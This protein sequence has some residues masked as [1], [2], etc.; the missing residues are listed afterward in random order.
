MEPKIFNPDKPIVLALCGKAGTGKTSVADKLVPSRSVH[1]FGPLTLD[2]T[3][4]AAPLY[5]MVSAKTKIEGSGR[6]DRI[7]YALHEIVVDLL[8]NPLYG[9]PSYDELYGLVNRLYDIPVAQEG[10]K[11]RYFMQTAGDLLRGY[12]EDCFV[13]RA[14]RSILEGERLKFEDTYYTMIL[15]DLRM[16][17]EAEMVYKQPNGLIIKLEADPTVRS[18]R[19]LRRDEGF[20]TDEEMNHNSEK[21]DLIPKE[22]ITQIINTTETT[23]KWVADEIK[24]IIFKNLEG[25]G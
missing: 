15:S 20:M 11:S 24:D 6:K 21:V 10:T 13:K 16:V 25:L 14:M 12:M 4:F 9:A 18:E 1:K 8:G 23:E 7:L 22:W 17:N 2:H 19:M 3:Y 5:N